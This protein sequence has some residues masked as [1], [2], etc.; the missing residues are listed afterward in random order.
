MVLFPILLNNQF[1]FEQ[2]KHLYWGL[3]EL[4][5]TPILLF[6]VRTNVEVEPGLRQM[7][8][9]LISL[10]THTAD[11]RTQLNFEDLTHA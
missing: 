7:E 2:C 3:R 8:M 10:T 4:I 9:K 11:G 6:E 1:Y 5:N